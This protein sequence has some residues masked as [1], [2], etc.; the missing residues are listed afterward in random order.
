ML[1]GL[2]QVWCCTCMCLFTTSVMCVVCVVNRVRHS[3]EGEIEIEILQVG[4]F[5]SEI[6][7]ILRVGIQLRFFIFAFLSLPFDPTIA[8]PNDVPVICG[9][10]IP[11][12]LFLPECVKLLARC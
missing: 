5:F 10:L 9:I 7:P 4:E 3:F 11:L 6:P 8:R 12:E 2:P 1:N